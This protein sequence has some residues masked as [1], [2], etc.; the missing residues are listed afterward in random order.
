MSHISRGEAFELLKDRIVH[1]HCKDRFT[2]EKVGCEMKMTVDGIKMYP[3]AVGDGCIKMHEIVSA[4][5]K[6][7]YDGI[8]T[9]EHFGAEDQLE[10]I[11]RSVGFFNNEE[12]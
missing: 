9:I 10:Y 6:R 7:G 12:K 11:K 1:V 8:Y 4:L 5:E 2:E 3:A